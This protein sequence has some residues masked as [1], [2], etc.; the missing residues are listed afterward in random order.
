M[1]T[2]PQRP[3]SVPAIDPIQELA[4]HRKLDLDAVLG[5]LKHD[6]IIEAGDAMKVRADG[7]SARGKMELHPIALI[8]NQK[9]V[10]PLDKKPLSL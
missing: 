6:G 8:A 10:N 5:A 4:L 2:V 3:T 1:A 9:L 7:R